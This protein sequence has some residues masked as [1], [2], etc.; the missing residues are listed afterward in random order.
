MSKRFIC[1]LCVMLSIAL[2]LGGCSLNPEPA[3]SDTVSGNPFEEHD[4]NTDGILRMT[5]GAVSPDPEKGVFTYDGDPLQ[6]TYMLHNEG[7]KAEWGFVIYVNGVM[8]PYTVEG[9]DG[10]STCHVFT[11]EKQ[12][13]EDLK[14]SFVPVVGKAGEE[15]SII[16]ATMLMPSYVLPEEEL[17][18]GY[19]YYHAYNMSLPMKLVMKKD[20]PNKNVNGSVATKYEIGEIPSWAEGVNVTDAILESEGNCI[21]A[22]SKTDASFDI[23]IAGRVDQ[24][25]RISFYVN[26]KLVSA[27]NGHPYLDVDIKKDKLITLSATVLAD[28]M[29]DAKFAYA[30]IVPIMDTFSLDAPQIV[31]TISKSIAFSEPSSTTTLPSNSTT[32]IADTTA[33]TSKTTA[34]QPT[35]NVPNTELNNSSF[36]KYSDLLKSPAPN[37]RVLGYLM[38]KNSRIFVYFDSTTI[39]NTY[40]GG[41]YDVNANKYVAYADG[42]NF[43]KVQELENGLCFYKY[44]QERPRFLSAAHIYNYQLQLQKTVDLTSITVNNRIMSACV[45][46]EGDRFV[47]AVYKNKTSTI[48]SVDLD[49]RDSKTVFSY[50]SPQKSNQLSEIYTIQN[51]SGDT[52]VFGGNAYVP[53]DGTLM[54][55]GCVSQNGKDL[56][57]QPVGYASFDAKS[58]FVTSVSGSLN[59]YDTAYDGTAYV[60]D[61]T[62]KKITK[63]QFKNK[64]ESALVVV[65]QNGK[66]VG[67][68][69]SNILRLYE[70]STSRC[71]KE[72]IIS[73]DTNTSLSSSMISIDDAKKSVYLNANDSLYMMAF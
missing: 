28:D 62:T 32:R 15:L 30:V 16:Y 42:L 7:S 14:I 59:M 3:E 72:S 34:N 64:N 4:E 37:S 57:F 25:Y 27:F 40:W 68:V 46:Y 29:T 61:H 67:T 69:Q 41:I 39:Q 21:Y 51:V 49:L 12:T 52:I 70:V 31:K 65:S 19:G 2:V 26:H 73:A 60:L 55:I 9:K 33:K 58:P 24:K 56:K 71:I 66:Y 17:D 38:L 13:R 45:S 23:L 22:K 44:T 20:A 11:I 10:E 54:G 5:H 53:G 50:N 47:Y 18:N 43:G 63:V 8:Q 48:Y 1:V 36:E 35:E 6:L